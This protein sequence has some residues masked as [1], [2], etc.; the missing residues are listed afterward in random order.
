MS[1]EEDVDFIARTCFN[2]LVIPT[3]F[4]R[5]DVFEHMDLMIESA[6]SGFGAL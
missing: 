6:T 1:V 3:T 4:S 2:E 5:R